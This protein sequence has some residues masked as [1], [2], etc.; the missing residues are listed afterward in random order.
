MTISATAVSPSAIHCDPKEEEP[1][2]T[3]TETSACVFQFHVSVEFSRIVNVT[4][5]PVPFA[6]TL[7]VPVQPVQKT[8]VWFSLKAIQDLPD[9]Q[10]TS[11]P[12]SKQ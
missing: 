11:V 8:R 5:V 2:E 7:P 10:Q 1:P 4:F 6:G 3:E 12:E 9:K